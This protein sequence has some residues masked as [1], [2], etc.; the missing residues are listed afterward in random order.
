MSGIPDVR[1]SSATID[2][3]RIHSPEH[4]RLSRQQ[5]GPSAGAKPLASEGALT[6]TASATASLPSLHDPNSRD[7]SKNE[8]GGSTAG[9]NNA[10]ANSNSNSNS[11]SNNSNGNSTNNNGTNDSGSGVDLGPSHTSETESIEEI[12][13]EDLEWIASYQERVQ[14]LGLPLDVLK[15]GLSN[16]GMSPDTLRPVYLKLAVHGGGLEDISILKDYVYLQVLELPRNNISDCSVLSSMRYLVQLDLSG[17]R[18]SSVPRFDPPPYNLQV[19]D[20]SKNQIT[21]IG[22]SLSHPFLKKLCLDYNLVENISGLSGCKFLS[23]LSLAHN[24]IS[25]IDNLDGLPIVYLNLSHNSVSS[26]AGIHGLP[27]IEELNLSHNV[28]ESLSTI[29]VNHPSLRTLLLHSNRIVDR[30]EIHHLEGLEM[31]RAL[32]LETN[33]I[34]DDPTFRLWLVYRL[35][36]LVTFNGLPVSPEEKI[37]ALNIYC[38]P[39]EVVASIQ[40]IETQM[41]QLRWYAKIRAV[42]LMRAESLQPLVLCGP[43]DTG[44]RALA[45]ALVE[46]YPDIYKLSVSYTSRPPRKDEIDGVDHHFVSDLT[47]QSM[48]LDGLLVECVETGGHHYGNSLDEVDR[49]TAEGKI[50][51]LIVEAIGALIVQRSPLKCKYVSVV[52][53]PESGGVVSRPDSTDELPRIDT[54]EKYVNS[55]EATLHSLARPPSRSTTAVSLASKYT[56]PTL[57][58]C[59]IFGPDFETILQKL[60]EFCIVTYPDSHAI[61]G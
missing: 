55:S 7:A 56:D 43:P 3:A 48:L 53:S 23:H 27:G 22:D 8:H 61:R 57:F 35:A 40:H 11:N 41:T 60:C 31:L 2:N 20:L 44:K 12:S 26:I 16:L 1:V 37:R 51:I 15:R 14:R 4:S 42:D 36:R 24:R 19:M 21:D 18:L 52:K 25:R 17:N 39:P 38:P 30:D 29:D 28:I 33:P 58:D 50:C 10:N 45:K 5:T 32:T 49:V 59:I 34:E 47:L 9:I 13:Q 6:D 46:I 54:P